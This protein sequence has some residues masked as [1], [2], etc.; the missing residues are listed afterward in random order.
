MT[1]EADRAKDAINVAIGGKADIAFLR[2]TCLLLTDRFRRQ[3]ELARYFKKQK[4]ATSPLPQIAA[5][6]SSSAAMA[7]R[8]TSDVNGCAGLFND[9]LFREIDNRSHGTRDVPKG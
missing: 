2:R 3:L 7:R 6:P 1:T 8:S 5:V 9:C 4:L